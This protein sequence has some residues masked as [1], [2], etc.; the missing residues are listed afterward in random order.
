[1]RPA[2]TARSLRLFAA[3]QAI[4]TRNTAASPPGVCCL[5]SGQGLYDQ[6]DGDVTA[7]AMSVPPP[8]C[9]LHR[10][11]F[12]QWRNRPLGR[13]PLSAW[14]INRQLGLFWWGHIPPDPGA[15]GMSEWVRHTQSASTGSVHQQAARTLPPP[16]ALFQPFRPTLHLDSRSARGRFLAGLAPSSRNWNFFGSIFSPMGLVERPPTRTTASTG[17]ADVLSGSASHM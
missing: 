4:D 8:L 1:M 6:P 14:T 12:L 9:A 15:R 13:P 2:L 11:R 3:R 7:L 10:R 17:L 5:G 16:R